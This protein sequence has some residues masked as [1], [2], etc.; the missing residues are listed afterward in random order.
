VDCPPR[1]TTHTQNETIR[2]PGSCAT[3]LGV[4][5]VWDGCG[6]ILDVAGVSPWSGRR[7]LVSLME[8]PGGL[9]LVPRRAVGSAV[10][11]CRGGNVGRKAREDANVW[12]VDPTGPSLKSVKETVH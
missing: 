2:F 6:F 7:A 9:S 4:S 12:L 5:H 1:T 3:W 10:R 11:S 8:I